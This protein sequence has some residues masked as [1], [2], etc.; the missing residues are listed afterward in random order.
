MTRQDCE[1]IAEL[2]ISQGSTTLLTAHQFR[3]DAFPESD[4]SQPHFYGWVA[5]E[6][7]SIIGYTMISLAYSTW[8]SRGIAASLSDVYVVPHHRRRGI[9][10]ALIHAA[11]VWLTA[12]NPLQSG[13]SRKMDVVVDQTNQAAISFLE[14]GCGAINMTALEEW[15]SF[16]LDSEPLRRLAAIT[17]P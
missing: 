1:R 6:D 11:L 16:V 9:G 2:I 13:Q 12:N 10:S 5:T 14:D 8:D 7:Q 15:H 3:E 17:S 4:S